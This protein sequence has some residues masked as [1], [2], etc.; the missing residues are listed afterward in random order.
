MLLSVPGALAVSPPGCPAGG[1]VNSAA[2]TLHELLGVAGGT[3]TTSSGTWTASCG[4][5]TGPLYYQWQRSTDLGVTWT[6]L[7]TAQSYSPTK[8]DVDAWLQAVVTMCNAYDCTAVPDSDPSEIYE[9]ALGLRRQYSPVTRVSIDDQESLQVNPADGNLVLEANDFSL[10]GIAGFGYRFTRS[11][12]SLNTTGLPGAPNDLSSLANPTLSAGWSDVPNLDFFTAKLGQTNG[13]VRYAGDGGYEITFAANGSAYTSPPGSDATLVGSGSGGLRTYVLTFD[14]TGVEEDFNSSGQLTDEYDRN[15]NT[16]HH[17]QYSW[18]SGKLQSVTDTTGRTTTFNYTSGNL[19]SITTPCAGAPMNLAGTASTSGGSLAS[20]SYFYEVT[21]VSSGRESTVSSE[22]NPTVTGPTG[23]VSLSWNAVAGASSYRIYRGTTSGGESVY[24]TSSTTSYT[25]TGSTGTSASPPAPAGMCTYAYTYSGGQLATFTD[26]TGATTT[27]T[28]N[29]T[30]LL[31]KVSNPLSKGWTIAY[32]SQNRVSS[33]TENRVRFATP[34]GTAFSSGG[35]LATGTYYFEVS[36]IAGGREVQLSNERSVAVT[37]PSGKVTLTWNAVP[38]AASYRVYR[39]TS[40]GGENIY[41]TTSSTS[42]TDTGGGTTG[43]PWLPKNTFSY[44]LAPTTLCSTGMETDVSDPYGNTTEYCT[45]GRARVYKSEDPLSGITST[46]FTD[47]NSGGLYCV[48]GGS[49]GETLDDQPCSITDA[50]GNT[51]K[52][53]YQST[54]Q[55]PGQNLTQEQG[56]TQTTSTRSHWYYAYSSHLYEPS[57]FMDPNGNTT[58]YNYDSKGNLT[59]STDPLS[60][61]TTYCYD[62]AGE[63]TYQY[64]PIAVS[65]LAAPIGSAGTASSTGGSLATGTYYYEVTAISS[66]GESVGSCE[67]SEAVTGPTGSVALSWNAVTGA[68][69]YRIYRGTSSGGESTYY[70]SSSPAFTDTGA[71]GTSGSPPPTPYE[72]SYTYDTSN[73]ATGTIGD[74]ASKTDPLGNETTYTYDG[75]GHQTSK[76]DPLGNVSGGTPA[77]YTTSSTHDADGRTLSVTNERGYT[78]AYAYDAA[79]NKFTTTDA[80]S[81]VTTDCYSPTNQVIAEY[82][83]LA[84]TVNC[85]SPP[86]TNVTYY[87]YDANG[88]QITSTD[89]L[90]NTTTDCYDAKNELTAEFSPRAGTV[91]DCS[92]SSYVTSYTYDPVGNTW[93]ETDTLSATQSST[94]QYAYYADNSLESVT[95][96]VGNVTGYGYDAAGNQV[97]VTNPRG[98]TTQSIYNADNQ[99][100]CS[101]GGLS[102]GSGSSFVCGVGNVSTDAFYCPATKTCPTTTYTYDADGNVQTMVSPDNQ[103]SGSPTTDCYDSGDEL[104]S[105]F[106]PL[107][108]VTAPCPPL[109]LGG[110]ALNTGGSLTTGTYYYEVTALN[111]AGESAASTEISTGVT[112][113]T[114]SVALSWN[115]V[116]GATSYRIYRGTSSGGESTYYTSSSATFTDTGASGTSG[117]PPSALLAY[118]TRYT[119]DANGNKHTKQ[120]AMGT[121]TFGY[122]HAAELTSISYANASGNTNPATP[123]VSYTFDPVGNRLTMSDGGSGTVSYAYNARDK[124]CSV[125]RGGTANCTW[126]SGMFNYGYDAAGNITGQ[127]Y[128]DGTSVSKTYDADGN[129]SCVNGTG[130]NCAGGT[131]Y[132]YYQNDSLE[133]TTLPSSPTAYTETRT[134]DNAGQLASIATKAGS[135]TLAQFVYTLNA[136]GSPTTVARTGNA[137]GSVDCTVTNSYDNNERLGTA[138]YDTTGGCPLDGAG[139]DTFTYT[140]DADGNWK[141]AAGGSTTNYYPSNAADE[142]CLVTTNSSAT[143]SSGGS[144]YVYDGNGNE[145]SDPNSGHTYTYDLENRVTCTD[146]TGSS[147]TGGTS[148]TYDGDGNLLTSTTSGVTTNYTW[149]TNTSDGI[150]AD[151]LETTGG[152]LDNR[153]VYGN[154]RISYTTTIGTPGTYYYAYDGLGSVVDTVDSS[155]NPGAAL[156]YEPYGGLRAGNALNEMQ[157]TGGLEDPAVNDSSLYSSPTRAYDT[158]T[159]RFLSQDPASNPGDTAGTYTYANNN[160]AANAE[161]TGSATSSPLS[162]TI[163]YGAGGAAQLGWGG[164]PQFTTGCGAFQCVGFFSGLNINITAGFSLIFKGN[165]NSGWRAHYHATIQGS[166]NNGDYSIVFTIEAV[167][168]V[169][170]KAVPNGEWD[171]HKPWRTDF[172]PTWPWTANGSTKYPGVIPVRV[173]FSFIAILNNQADPPPDPWKYTVYCAVR[174]GYSGNGSAPQTCTH[175]EEN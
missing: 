119:Y 142:L 25:D 54:G 109:D 111:S 146:G 71:S 147:C 61:T 24:Y 132:G 73:T 38:G 164:M 170:T 78:T 83:A 19:T 167:A 6:D 94:T 4:H 63:L 9:S 139:V 47:S 30:G 86:S 60:N 41:H 120:T 165:N 43:S 57:S 171:P 22:I 49:S 33:I 136:D 154:S 5:P 125:F 92:G 161:L 172:G 37:G 150:P 159:G 122:D 131:S 93:S 116:A 52:Y 2:P 34:T 14:K 82:D 144:H 35:S 66:A 51:T 169:G 141:S 68:T 103:G 166:T 44:T 137:P 106:N 148:Y 28:Y 123:N 7:S 89:Q 101:Q 138:S 79:G 168:N 58:N 76:V 114:G 160:P 88:N 104:I 62:S 69:S 53:F 96:G 20:G 112:G 50:N 18:S 21:A 39:G 12:N 23:S 143:C 3:L 80:N 70:T 121:I 75:A 29:A 158:T 26:P 126:S 8:A 74:R 140:Y 48:S 102:T 95:D 130:S 59:S 46:D 65:S 118:E 10:P 115:P 55:N 56:P 97:S 135:T 113:P 129:L 72:T 100:A 108:A 151:V 67:I 162:T 27:Y 145:L 105:Q 156:T 98:Y 36:A 128:P 31:S 11:Y 16:S 90:G 77:N 157:Y 15:H 91:S 117:L 45:D 85:S 152:T 17:I 174:K 155:G 13:D 99:V 87:N 32:D 107:T 163:I 64:S 127:T 1:P 153:Y 124:L 81:H 133:T 84:G 173:L 110:T 40:A 149:D 42:Y 175:I 134:F